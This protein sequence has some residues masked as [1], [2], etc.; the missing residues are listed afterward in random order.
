MFSREFEY[1]RHVKNTHWLQLQPIKS[2][3]SFISPYSKTSCERFEPR[4]HFKSRLSLIVR[5]NVILN[6][7]VVVDSDWRF[8]NNLCVSHLQS[9]SELYHVVLK[10]SCITWSSYPNQ[11]F[12]QC[13]LRYSALSSTTKTSAT[14]EGLSS[15]WI[16]DVLKLLL[17]CS[18]YLYVQLLLLLHIFCW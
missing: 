10:V 2:V 15:K 17:S 13:G 11:I 6:R 9:Q 8:D 14:S 18:S 3:S 5:V 1:T 12:I 4:T 16:R 7:T